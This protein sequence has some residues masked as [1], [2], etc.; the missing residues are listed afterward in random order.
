MDIKATVFCLTFK[1]ITNAYRYNYKFL[2]M[3]EQ[4]SNNSYFQD[5]AVLDVVNDISKGFGHFKN[6][7]SSSQFN[8]VSQFETKIENLQHFMH[9]I[10]NRITTETNSLSTLAK[11]SLTSLTASSLM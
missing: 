2:L 11:V 10:D 6:Q 8:N 7:L 5:N 3:I 9:C 1:V 4:Y